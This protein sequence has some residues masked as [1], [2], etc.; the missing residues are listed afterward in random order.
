MGYS[1]PAVKRD[2]ESRG[3]RVEKIRGRGEPD[4]V[5]E[6]DGRRIYVDAKG[7]KADRAPMADVEI[8]QLLKLRD[9][10]Q[11]GFEAYLAFVTKETLRIDYF[12]WTNPP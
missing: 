2:L 10:G 8:R 7:M 5:A 1:E 4:F 3:Y 6:K 12:R 9:Y 11:S